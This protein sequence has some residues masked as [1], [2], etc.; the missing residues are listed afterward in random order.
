M[1]GVEYLSLIKHLKS[2]EG[3]H[4]SSFSSDIAFSFSVSVILSS[5]NVLSVRHGVT[6]FQNCLFSVI[7]SLDEVIF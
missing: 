4:Y 7:A 3:F 2:I 5:F 6:V 1:E